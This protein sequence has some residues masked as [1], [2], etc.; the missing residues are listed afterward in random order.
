MIKPYYKSPNRDF[1][2]LHGDCFQLL[3]EFDFKFSC[4]FADPTYFL[5]NGAISVQAGKIV[6]VNKGEWDKG[7]ITII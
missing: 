6:S 3:R 2:L 5:S 4:N 1:T 7:K